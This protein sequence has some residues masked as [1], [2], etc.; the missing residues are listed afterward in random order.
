[1]VD[2][3]GTGEALEM[4]PDLEEALSGACYCLAV[5]KAS[6]RMIRIYDAELADHGLTI[7]QFAL[8]AW[9]A[10][11]GAPTVQKL[12]DS[13]AMDQSAMSRGLGPLERNGLVESGADEADRRKRV[14]RLT[15]EGRR[16]L[17]AASSAWKAA[18]TRIEAGQPDTDMGAL[19]SAIRAMARS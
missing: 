2:D 7:V 12:A 18:Q 10:S 14:V 3:A 17:T 19:I 8:L 9:I 15:D 5:R 4:T 1:M 13:A 11:L 6:R 16:R